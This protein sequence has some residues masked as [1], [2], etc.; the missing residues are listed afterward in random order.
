MNR[1]RLGT[2]YSVFT[3]CALVVLLTAC[4]CEPN[5]TADECQQFLN[6]EARQFNYEYG[7]SGAAI[8]LTKTA[9]P[10]TFS[11]VGEVITYTYTIANN[12]KKQ[13]NAG[14][15]VID[16][17]VTV[18]CPTVQSLGLNQTVTCSG[19][20][21]VTDVDFY[22]GQVMNHASAEA[23]QKMATLYCTVENGCSDTTMTKNASYT[24][25][26]ET[27]VTVL[28][29][30]HPSLSLTKSANPTF[31]SGAQHITY[32]FTLTNNGNVPLTPP[33]TISDDR[34][35]DNWSCEEHSELL[36]GESMFC[37]G[38]YFTGIGVRWT[39]TNTAVAYAQYRDNL[40]IS[41]TANASILFRQPVI[42]TSIP[43]AITEPPAP[44]CGDGIVNPELGEECDPPDP[45]E[46]LC[47]MYCK[48]PQ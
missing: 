23:T 22:E 39:I 27:T 2:F 30:A 13:F 1:N 43:K 14:L 35:S 7:S 10:A 46:Y 31:F 24:V 42:P 11:E 15:K 44:Y 20:Y 28:L 18:T 3:A 5:R 41:N 4:C 38:D 33:F 21:T 17:K 29:D 32:T 25:T 47:D 8:L 19:T 36:P 26:S 12:G 16:D 40:V 45:M 6:I 34:V 9:D 37:Q 48:I